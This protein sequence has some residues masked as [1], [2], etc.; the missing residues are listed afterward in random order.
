MVFHQHRCL[1]VHV[2]KT[3][4][5]AIRAFLGEGVPNLEVF[6]VPVPFSDAGRR[7]THLTARE[8]RAHDPEG[9]W[10][11]YFS[12]AFVRNPWDRAVSEH[13]WRLRQRDRRMA[14]DTLKDFLRAA[15]EGWEFQHGD[16]RHLLPQKAY[17]TSAEGEVIVD[18][19]GRFE[20]LHE[21]MEEVCGRL[22]IPFDGLD[23][24]N[25]SGREARDTA[26]WYDGESR[27]LV[28][29]LWGEDIAFFGYEFPASSGAR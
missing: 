19:V 5:Q 6:P 16:R 23:G 11:R 14:F 15:L 17:V 29:E 28:E 25:A 20:S 3:A 22:G 27:R 13:C 18:W 10:E 12:F 1:H 7:G 4:G 9:W 2:P 21:G 24:V 26:Q 8:M